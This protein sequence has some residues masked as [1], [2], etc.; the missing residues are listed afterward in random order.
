MTLESAV[1][2]SRRGTP[3]RNP[4]VQKQK[5]LLHHKHKH[6]SINA[7]WRV[8]VRDYFCDSY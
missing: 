1:D 7:N 8:Q 5:M 6:E 2:T 4:Y 3:G